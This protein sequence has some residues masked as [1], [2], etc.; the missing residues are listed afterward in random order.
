MKIFL[1]QLKQAPQDNTF[2]TTLDVIDQHYNFTPCEFKNA[3][4]VNQA[5]QNNGSCKIFA[6]GQIHHLTKDQVLHCFGDYYRIDVLQ[7]PEES[8][9]QNIRNFINQ[10]WSG[11]TFNGTP[12][13]KK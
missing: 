2:E 9:H 4:L 6:F 10:G 13:S 12:L 8:N 1:K 11:I 3:N 5:N 7:H